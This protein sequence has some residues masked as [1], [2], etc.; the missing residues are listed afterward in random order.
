MHFEVL[1]CGFRKDLWINYRYAQ[2]I[3]KKKRV[4]K[5][6]A[7]LRLLSPITDKNAENEC[8]VCKTNHK[9]G[10]NMLNVFQLSN[11]LSTFC[12]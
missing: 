8:F 7:K 4:F 10:I 3:H 6:S 12:G 9:K 1:A 11:S 5:K 2:V